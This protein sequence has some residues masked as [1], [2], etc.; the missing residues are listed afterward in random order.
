MDI[1]NIENIHTLEYE[2]LRFIT[3]TIHVYQCFSTIS[4]SSHSFLNLKVKPQPFFWKTCN[5]TKKIDKKLSIF[6]WSGIIFGF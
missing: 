5:T 6:H 3:V 4:L 1:K 2:L